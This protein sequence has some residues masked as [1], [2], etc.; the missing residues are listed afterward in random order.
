LAIVVS[1][2]NALS[3]PP[4]VSFALTTDLFGSAVVGVAVFALIVVL[5]V[6]PGTLQIF[7]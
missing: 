2:L 6:L 3:A 1:V 5:V 7:T 4:G